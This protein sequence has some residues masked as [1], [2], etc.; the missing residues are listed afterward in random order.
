MG[1]DFDRL[2]RL[3]DPAADR[4]LL[5]QL[6]SGDGVALTEL[7]RRH[8]PLVMGACRRVLGR[9]QDAEDAFQAAFLVLAARAGSVR[10]AGAVGAW[11]YRTAR[12]VA[13][14]LRDKERRRRRHE[15][16]A[17]R[18]EAVGASPGEEGWRAVL[19]EELGLLPERF[20]APLVGCYLAGRT[21]E[22]LAR[23]LGWSLSTLRRRL[24]RGRELLRGRLVRRGVTLPAGA[25]LVGGVEPV[26]R[27]LAEAVV[28]TVARFMGGDRGST[29]SVLA[30][31]VLAMMARAKLLKTGAVAL[32][33]VGAVVVW[34]AAGGA[35]QPAPTNPNPLGGQAQKADR[36]APPRA[37]TVAQPAGKA[38]DRIKPG[39]RLR[40]RAR[41]V[42]ETDPIDGVYV[43]EKSGAVPLGPAY[44][45]RLKVAGLPPEEA[46]AVLQ[47]RL[48]TVAPAASAQLTVADPA[49]SPSG[50][51]EERVRRLEQEVL[52][53][54]AAI[55]EMRKGL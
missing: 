49:D 39:D 22:D 47:A 13:L 30:Q 18:P 2:L 52:E 11:L 24:E 55:R 48:R 35:A 27:A 17:G 16:A 37:E 31:G 44:G 51:L 21:Q 46:E 40:I 32:S 23:E 42:F 5:G 34:Q 9:E 10:K 50:Q 38:D 28:Q 19:D 43:V 54:R 8:G 29:P 15:A 41:G 45:G 7:V 1:G 20:R 36:T 4:D 12:H 14:R 3:A 33:L 53:L 6:P 25:A 26:P